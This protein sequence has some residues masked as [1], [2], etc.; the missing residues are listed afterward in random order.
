MFGNFGPYLKV[1]W[2]YFFLEFFTK[3]GGHSWSGFAPLVWQNHFVI[4]SVWWLFVYYFYIGVCA[5]AF[6]VYFLVI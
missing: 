2:V 5:H 3:L 6:F 4:F 1:F